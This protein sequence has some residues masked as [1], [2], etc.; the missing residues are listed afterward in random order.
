MITDFHEDSNQSNT[1]AIILCHGY[2]TASSIA[3]AA[4]KMIGTKI[5]DAIDMQLDMSTDKI[6]V[7]LNSFIKI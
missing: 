4:N 1:V 3:D 7:Q 6:V 5:Y 2:S